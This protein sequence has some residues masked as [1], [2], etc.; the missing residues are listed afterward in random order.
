MTSTH[1]VI[2]SSSA[3][4]PR[5]RDSAFLS[6]IRKPALGPSFTFLTD[7]TV[8]LSRDTGGGDAEDGSTTYVAEVFRS[9]TM[10]SLSS[11]L[12]TGARALIGCLALED[13]VLVQDQRGVA[14]K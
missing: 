13:V 9:R 8:W 12:L 4:S 3:S 6:T 11:S 7:T 14:T 10:V 5:N 2:N 1:Q